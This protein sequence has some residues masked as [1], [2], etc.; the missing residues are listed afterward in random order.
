[1][2][3]NEAECKVLQLGQY[4]YRLVDEWIE[5]IPVEKEL[6]ILVGEKLVVSWHCVHS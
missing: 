1:M 4:Q 3:F 6:G 5:S 2:K